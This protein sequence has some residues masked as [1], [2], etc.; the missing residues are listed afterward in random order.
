M[1]PL[2]K[3]FLRPAQ[4]ITYFDECTEAELQDMSWDNHQADVL[5]SEA[6]VSDSSDSDVDEMVKV[7]KLFLHSSVQDTLTRL[8]H[9]EKFSHI[10]APLLGKDKPFEEP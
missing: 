8:S 3:R 5:K 9:D 6:T 1:L 4:I 10:N 2:N 7:D